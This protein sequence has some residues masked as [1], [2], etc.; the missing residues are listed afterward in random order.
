[1]ADPINNWDDWKGLYEVVRQDSQRIEEASKRPQLAQAAAAAL[2]EAGNDEDY[3]NALLDPQRTGEDV[4]AALEAG[5]GDKFERL[6][7]ASKK[8]KLTDIVGGFES[9]RLLG[10]LDLYEHEADTSDYGNATK[11]YNEMARV[12]GDISE[13]IRAEDN[14]RAREALDDKI[15]AYLTQ[16]QESRYDGQDGTQIDRVKLA[17]KKVWQANREFALRKYQKIKSKELEDTTA[18]FYGAIGGESELVN[19]IQG[20]I[21]D[22]E[23]VFGLYENLYVAEARAAQQAGQ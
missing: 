1:M 21:K 2:V 9:E 23:A 15:V 16:D 13:S 8:D 12:R 11:I 5:R 22:D 3:A 10:A 18:E 14:T 4:L 19:Y 20:T 6:Q 17:E 7:E